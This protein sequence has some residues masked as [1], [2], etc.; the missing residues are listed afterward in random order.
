MKV[1]IYSTRESLPKQAHYYDAGFDLEANE[2]VEVLPQGEPV[3]VGTGISIA[4]PKTLCAF[5]MPRS[6]LAAKYGVTVVNSPG[7]I[8]PGYRGEVKVALINHHP[9]RTHVVSEGDRIAQLLFV[10]FVI[11]DF[12]RVLVEQFLNDINPTDGR[13]EGGFGSSGK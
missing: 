1:G 4:L 8:D 7:L 5:V 9:T 3:L 13:G 10:P 2:D 12:Q 11:P 6:G